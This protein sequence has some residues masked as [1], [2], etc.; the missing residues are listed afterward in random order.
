MRLEGTAAGAT[1]P[2]TSWSWTVASSLPST[3]ITS[4]PSNGSH[5]YGAALSFAYAATAGGGANGNVVPLSRVECRLAR[6]NVTAFIT[7]P[8]PL[9]D[10]AACANASGAALAAAS[11]PFGGLLGTWWRAAEAAAVSVSG[12]FQLL[13]A[14]AVLESGAAYAFSAR[15]ID[16]AGGV[17][18]SPPSSFFVWDAGVPLSPSFT[19]SEGLTTTEGVITP[20]GALNVSADPASAAVTRAFRVAAAVGGSVWLDDGATEVPVG[21]AAAA[22]GPGASLLLRFRPT[23]G[24]FSGDARGSAFSFSVTALTNA[25]APDAGLES[26]PPTS[27]FFHVAPRHHAPTVSPGTLL[28]FPD[29]FYFEGGEAATAQ[30]G[31]TVLDLLDTAPN[32]FSDFDA[33]RA[34]QPLMGVAVVAQDASRG[35]WQ[36]SLDAG[37]NWWPLPAPAATFGPTWN[38]LPALPASALNVSGATWN[39]SAAVAESAADAGWR[40]W[41]VTGAGVA[42]NATWADLASGGGAAL[43]RLPALLLAA[44]AACRLRFRRAPGEGRRGAGPRHQ[45]LKREPAG[46]VLFS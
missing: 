35:V 21:G 25:S 37:A 6:L 12:A 20:A 11:D 17:D 31:A 2:S 15:A 45:I 27:V 22:S 30:H 39:A 32:A 16:T 29:V 4:G 23:A 41:N 24:L 44:D 19:P 8:W 46:R 3:A 5:A 13:N 1:P 7:A 36:F 18:A 34:G 14:S 43:A 26:Y 33:G 38:L 40:L 42:A 10:W 28:T 9:Q